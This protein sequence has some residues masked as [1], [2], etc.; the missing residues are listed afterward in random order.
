MENY[1]TTDI[2]PAELTTYARWVKDKGGRLVAINGYINDNNENIVAYTFEYED[3]RET[4]FIRNVNEI[5]TL[6]NDYK[7]AAQWFEEEIEE[8]MKVKFIG[9]EKSGRLFLPEEFKEGE[10]QIL[11]MPLDELKKLKDKKGGN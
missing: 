7:G 5:P 2:E 1:K 10:G 8:V 3:L 4:A 6:T 11:V 9:L